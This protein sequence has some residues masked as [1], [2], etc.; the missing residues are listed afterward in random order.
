MIETIDYVERLWVGLD[1]IKDM[2]NIVVTSVRKNGLIIL[3]DVYIGEDLIY[4]IRVGE[5]EKY[6]GSIV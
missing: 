2:Y 1:K 5:V 3:K 4:R 6:F